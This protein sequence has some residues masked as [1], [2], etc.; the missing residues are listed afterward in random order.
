MRFAFTFLLL[1]LSNWIMAQHVV[2]GRVADAKNLTLPGATV[3]IKKLNISTITDET[4][5]YKLLNVPD[6]THTISVSYIGF[7]MES[8]TVKISGKSETVNIVLKSAN[9]SELGDVIV[10]STTGAQLK[11]LNQQKAS[12]RIVNVIS[13]DQI[14]RF[15]TQSRI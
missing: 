3:A 15:P 9:S 14:G 12:N 2:S 10:T 6:G 4:G 13:A 11:A 1:L 5:S 8:Q 7:N